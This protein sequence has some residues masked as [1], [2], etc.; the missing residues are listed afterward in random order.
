VVTLRPIF[1]VLT[2]LILLLLQSALVQLLPP[3]W[4]A[5]AFGLLVVLHLGLSPRWSLIGQVVLAFL[6]GYLFDLLAGAPHGTHALVYTLTV[7]L[8]GRLAVRVSV[9]RRL[10]RV[11]TSFVVALVGALAVVALR[12]L[13]SR[14]GGFGGLRWAPA[15]AAI[16][17]LLAPPVLALLEL[18]EGKNEN[19]RKRGGLHRRKAM[20]GGQLPLG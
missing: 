15:E 8:V 13:V 14:S 12:A 11:A 10:P 17:A 3:F 2:A 16:T 4:P 6:L 5:P 20:G 18:I 7:L 1:L 19:Q 9:S